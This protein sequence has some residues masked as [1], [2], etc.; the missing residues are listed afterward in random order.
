MT[1]V[2]MHVHTL[3]FHLLKLGV[4]VAHFCSALKAALILS[5]SILGTLV[6]SS[7]QS[8]SAFRIPLLFAAST[9]TERQ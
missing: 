1:S 3:H 8:S 4:S 9:M 7:E 2:A 6:G 5:L